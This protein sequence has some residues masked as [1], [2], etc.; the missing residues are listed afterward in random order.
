[1]VGVYDSVDF[2]SRRTAQKSEPI[3]DANRGVGKR[4]WR[5]AVDGTM[6]KTTTSLRITPFLWLVL[7]STSVGGGS[8]KYRALTLFMSM[9]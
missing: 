1:M 2:Y 8:H 6:L 3:R 5:R 4:M 9:N 7:T